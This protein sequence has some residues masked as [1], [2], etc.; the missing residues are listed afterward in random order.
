MYSIQLKEHNDMI[1]LLALFYVTMLCP[2]CSKKIEDCV[3]VIGEAQSI[4][5]DGTVLLFFT[6]GKERIIKFSFF[7]S[8]SRHKGSIVVVILS[9]N[10]KSVFLEVLKCTDVVGRPCHARMTE[11]G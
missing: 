5:E 11:S 2:S 10:L 1:R 9:H 3:E 6:G 7:L 8:S 4:S